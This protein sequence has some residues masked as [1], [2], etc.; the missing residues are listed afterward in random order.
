MLSPPEYTSTQLFS[1]HVE[2]YI[3]EIPHILAFVTY[4]GGERDFKN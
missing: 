1:L 3:C 2:A 4:T